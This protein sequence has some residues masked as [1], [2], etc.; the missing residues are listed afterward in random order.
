MD[1]LV[2]YTGFVGSNLYS[3][4][5]FNCVFNSKN[6]VEAFG[7][8][9]DL[10]VYA[11]VRA[12]KFTADR[13]PEEDL[14][15]INETLE[16]IQNINPKKLVLIS[17]VDVIPSPQNK[18]VYEDTLYETDRLTPYGQ[19]RLY[20]ENE[21]RKLCPMALVIRLPALFGEGLKK[22]FIYDLIN[23]IPAMLKKEKFEE[24]SARAPLLSDFYMEDE[25]G[26]FR[27][28]ANI[29]GDNRTMLKALFE[30]LGFSALNFTDSRSK[31]SFYNLKYLWE[32]IEILL[33]NSILLAHMATEPISVGDIYQ[34]VYGRIFVNEIMLQPFDYAFYKTRHVDLFKGKDGYIFRKNRI[35]AEVTEFLNEKTKH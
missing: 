5:K 4:H 16:N 34:S 22:N 6:I 15:H 35:I 23:F 2:G 27:L 20:L 17:T 30:N 33:D 19:N 3:Q 14:A 8:N 9:P 26:F 29:S 1:I 21:V 10:C 7:S 31:F 25:N 32:H 12:E 28:I 18:N 11:G 24:L 13:F